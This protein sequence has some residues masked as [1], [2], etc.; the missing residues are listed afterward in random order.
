MARHK[1]LEIV[2][3]AREEYEAVN[4]HS[5]Q[6]VLMHPI[7]LGLAELDACN[8]AVKHGVMEV[9]AKLKK[10]AGLYLAEDQAIEKEEVWVGTLRELQEMWNQRFDEISWLG[11]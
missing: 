4:G 10:I 11:E 5:P 6:V 1:L 8:F 7:T 3:D 9:P 2:I